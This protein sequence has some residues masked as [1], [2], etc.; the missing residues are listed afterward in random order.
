MSWTRIILGTVAATLALT[1]AAHAATFTVTGTADIGGSC[2]GNQCPSIRAALAAAADAPGSDTIMLTAGTYDLGSSGALA[3]D[4]AVTLRG[5]SARDTMIQASSA[6]R[7]L[8]ITAAA[9]ISHLTVANGVAMDGFGGNIRNTGATVSL[10]HVRVT[11]GNASTGAGIANLHGNMTIAD[12][13]IDANTAQYGGN[14]TSLEQAAGGGV[15]NFGDGLGSAALTLRNSTVALNAGYR[16]GGLINIGSA[17]N[18]VTLENV[19][20]ARNSVGAGGAGGI[21]N[22]EGPLVVG[23]SIVANNTIFSSGAFS[24]CVGV[25][26]SSQGWNV[27]SGDTCGFRQEA[28]QRDVGDAKLATALANAGSDTDVLLPDLDSRAINVQADGCQPADQREILRPQGPACDSGAVELTYPVRIDN[29]PPPTTSETTAQFAFSS[30]M[31]PDEFQCGLAGPSAP[32]PA[33]VPCQSGV[34]YDTLADGAYTFHVKAIQ[35]DETIGE[36][37]RDF[38]VSTGGGPAPITIDSGPEGLA[39]ETTATFTFSSSPGAQ[40]DCQ[41]YT[42]TDSDPAYEPCTSPYT[43]DGLV[44]GGYY[45]IVAPAGTHEFEFSAYRAFTVDTVKPDPP[46]IDEPAN[47]GIVGAHDI[48]ASGTA[49]SFSKITI[50]DGAAGRVATTE[51]DDSGHWQAGVTGLAEGRHDLTLVTTDEAGNDSDPTTVT[52][53]VD[54]TAPVATITSGPAGGTNKTTAAFTYEANEDATFECR[55]D[56]GNEPTNYGECPSSGETYST[57]INRVT[58][59]FRVRATD[60]VGHTGEE[61]TR[62]FTVNTGLPD[63]PVIDTPTDNPHYQSEATVTLSGTGS[64]GSTVVLVNG[65]TAPVIDGRWTFALNAQAEGRHDYTVRAENPAGQTG[66]DS[67]TV[68]VDHTAPD[69][70]IDSGPVAAGFNGVEFEFS[71]NESGAQFTCK[72]AGIFNGDTPPQG[73]CSSPETYQSLREGERYTFTVFAT[74]RAGNV[75]STPASVTFSYDHVPPVTQIDSTWQ[76]P[77]NDNTP[78]IAFSADP[79]SS[80]VCHVD[81]DQD[82]PCTSPLTLATLTDGGHVFSVKATDPAGNVQQDYTT[83]SFV[84]DTIAPE[85]PAIT[86]PDADVAQAVNSVRLRGTASGAVDVYDNGTLLKSVRY[87][88]G[89]W[90]VDLSNLSEGEHVFT[91]RTFDAAG[92]PSALSAPRKVTV[93]T[94]APTVTITSIPPSLTNQFTFDVLFSVSEAGVTLECKHFR[95]EEL[96]AEL[97]N[98][99]PWS[100]RELG[101]GTHRFEITATD[102]AGNVGPTVSREVTIDSAVPDPVEPSPVDATTFAF[103]PKEPDA[104]FECRLDGPGGDSG[105]VPCQSPKTY[106]GLAPGNYSFTLR[107]LDAAGNHAD[108]NPRAFSV[109][110]PQDPTPTPT[111]TP[112]AAVSPT[113]TPTVTPTPPPTPEI[114]ETIVVRPLSGKILV[115]VPGSDQFVEL[116]A[117]KGFPVGTEIDARNGKIQL[118]SEPGQGKPVQKAIFYGGIFTIVQ[119]NDGFVELKLSEEL[120]PCS[121]KKKKASAAA[122]K[123]KTRKL[124]GDGKGKF[125]TRGQY[126]AATIRGTRWLVEDSCEGTLTTVKNGV[127]SVHDFSGKKTILVRGGKSYLAKPKR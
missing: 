93:D 101:D 126:S 7:V 33:Y 99:S 108:A 43:R 25:E 82:A 115:R 72:L 63:T 52:T 39:N 79:G 94:V 89:I 26:A 84:V 6:T 90:A 61:V 41:L 36:V 27:E 47:G 73:G 49:E 100:F 40:F 106:S 30:T 118:T 66:T 44:D 68:Y 34:S 83:F 32:T 70:T 22:D 58:Y 18:S 114:A 51:T 28:D 56:I 42:P 119:G 76:S 57:L 107:T 3:I 55:L 45:F 46:V 23:S 17:Q 113:P 21:Y 11:G 62:R 116:D 50:S 53:T 59:V 1:P 127:V 16:A 109:A 91:A 38:T 80:F 110:P 121:K 13:L 87:D 31:A 37:T 5:T 2:T 85:P 95:P 12:S 92:N 112:I 24:D 9:T 120:A 111:P 15:A 67:T 60:S 14:V 71:S 104:A 10:D 81:G 102:A 20:L 74:D 98:C 96:V 19:T 29:G 123:P 75:D 88:G 65:G 64:P 105:F 4:T 54:T 124:W 8:D 97:S 69:T 48:I 122:K 77:T 35:N 125:R 117:T 78:T 86:S 103:S